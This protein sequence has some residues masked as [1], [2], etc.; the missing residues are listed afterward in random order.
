MNFDYPDVEVK[1]D[2]KSRGGREVFEMLFEKNGRFIGTVGMNSD[3]LF[4]SSQMLY[5]EAPG[6]PRTKSG[7][8][9]IW[10]VYT[11]SLPRFGS[12]M[13]VSDYI[14]DKKIVHCNVTLHEFVADAY[15]DAMVV[16]VGDRENVVTRMKDDFMVMTNFPVAEFSG[17]G[18]QGACGV[19]ADRYIA[20]TR[21]IM[22]HKSRFDVTRGMEALE[23]AAMAG[24]W[25]TQ[26]SMVFLP[27]RGEVYIALYRDYDRIWKLS[28]EDETIETYAGFEE[29]SKVGL[30][31]FGVTGT[32]LLHPDPDRGLSLG[33]I[34]GT[35][36]FVLGIGV[37][38]ILVK[39]IRR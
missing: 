7:E 29:P 33:A 20:V 13:E 2:V 23:K 1:F 12:V 31:L 28:I 18:Y 3:G 11:E 39:K 15:G 24:E 35:L 6:A 4:V 17:K 9:Y 22:D 14:E 36:L 34:A 38:F 30:G 5:P 25:S 8:I 37:A 27:K 32:R 16:E 10:K 21:H 19:G 26:C